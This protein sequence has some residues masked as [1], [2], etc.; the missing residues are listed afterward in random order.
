M[1]VG[2]DEP[3]PVRQQ[4]PVAEHVARHV[5]DA[6]HGERLGRDVDAEL[7]EVALDR[8]P[9]A[10][11]GDPERLVVVAA[12]AARGERVAE[13]EAALLAHA[14]RGV[15]ERRGAL[16]GRDDEVGVV[17]VEH[18]HALGMDDLALDEVVGQLQQPADVADV[19]ALDLGLERVAVRGRLLEVEA[20]LGAGRDDHGVLGDLRAHEPEDL[21]AV[22]LPVR[23]A[24]AA[25]GDLAA[26]QVDAL[27][28]RRV[29][30]DLE[31]RGRLGDRG[32]VGGAQL[33]RG[34]GAV[35]VERVRAQRRVDQAELVAQDAVVVERGHRVEVGDDL[36][37]QRR[38]GVL[39][40][41]PRRV[42][43]QL[44]V[45]HRAWP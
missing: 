24:D 21:G 5:A 34:D 11:R 4:H 33:E 10:A 36:L 3:D 15:G 44:E 28:R 22:V 40:A 18:P 37:A 42:E 32:D 45:A 19:L 25:A 8:L 9:R 39:V 12:G 31:Q 41:L 16:V 17:A 27:H 35:G 14:V 2:A 29:D 23:P 6:D 38:L 13:P 1:V 43:A 20:A 26:A 7:G 30:V